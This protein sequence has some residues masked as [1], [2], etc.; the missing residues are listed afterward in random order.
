MSFPSG[1]MLERRG[2]TG[3]S[4]FQTAMRRREGFIYSGPITQVLVW[5]IG[6]L[7]LAACI[8]LLIADDESGP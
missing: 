4:S 7:T 6:G 3:R 5:G 1:A 2:L 8:L